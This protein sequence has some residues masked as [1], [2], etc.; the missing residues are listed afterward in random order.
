[1][2]TTTKDP[3]NPVDGFLFIWTLM[4]GLDAGIKRAWQKMS[5]QMSKKASMEKREDEETDGDGVF[6]LKAHE[7]NNGAFCM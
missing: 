7:K 3:C 1:M 4:T 6:T 2:V 5:T